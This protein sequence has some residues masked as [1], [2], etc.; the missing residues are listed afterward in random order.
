[1]EQEEFLRAKNQLKS[2][3]FMALESRTSLADDMGRQV[4][5]YGKR[6]SAEDVGNK[7]DALSMQDVQR[8]LKKML[9]NNMPTVVAYGEGTDLLPDP[10]MIRDYYSEQL[11]YA[12]Y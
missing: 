9:T 11:R 1:M 2:Q 10:K 8:V 6:N 3:I 4:M 12:N 7:I 5:V